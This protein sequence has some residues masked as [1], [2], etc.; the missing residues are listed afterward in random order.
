M[1]SKLI[2]N[3]GAVKNLANNL[4]KELHSNNSKYLKEEAVEIK[5]AIQETIYGQ[6]EPW[7]ELKPSTIAQK[8]SSK[9]LI[10]TGQLVESI[11][12]T[13][14]DDL[15][16]AITP[17]G[18]HSSGLSNSELAMIHEYGTNKVPP[19]PFV[20]PTHA[21][22]KPQVEKEVVNIVA[23]TIKSFK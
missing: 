7:A 16:Y 22:V 12:V 8:G 15:T 13:P 3:W 20:Q 21:K 14:L 5:E 1:A 9:K 4:G 2:G 23:K 18:S 11:D 6:T 10:E 17:K 19:R